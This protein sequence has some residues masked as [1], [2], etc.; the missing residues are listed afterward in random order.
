MIVA[1]GLWTAA[2]GAAPWEPGAVAGAIPQ[3]EHHARV[4]HDPNA[5]ARLGV[6]YTRTGRTADALAAFAVGWG[7]PYYV[8]RAADAHAD[9]LRAHRRCAEAVEVR[10]ST[11]LGTRGLQE[12]GL[13]LDVVDDWRTCG[14][15]PQ[16]MTAAR[17]AWSLAPDHPGVHAALADVWR[18]AGHPLRAEFHLARALQAPGLAYRPWRSLAEAHLAAG[19]AHAAHGA[20]QRAILGHA[21][22]VDLLTLRVEALL[23]LGRAEQA[24]ALVDR[25]PWPGHQAPD[26]ACARAA[27]LAAVGREGEAASLQQQAARYGAPCVASRAASSSW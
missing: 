24:A 15:V 20:L 1:W 12:L 6:A 8:A 2:A 16:A 23:A 17:E 3:L 25:R 13:V 22:D 26:A 14:S 4:A 27:A 5:Y 19:D 21:R 9:A 10:R 18:D 11:Q 7:S